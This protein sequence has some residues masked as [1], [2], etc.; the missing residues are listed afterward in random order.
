MPVQLQQGQSALSGSTNVGEAFDL[1]AT[2]LATESTYAGVIRLVEAAQRSRAPM[3]RLADRYA[4]VFLGVT[5]AM[6]AG[7]WWLTGDSVRRR[8]SAGGCDAL[9]AHSGGPSRHRR[10]PIARG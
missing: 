10:R 8:G 2:R 7:A 6:A 3:A 4:I 5:V 1:L 9:S